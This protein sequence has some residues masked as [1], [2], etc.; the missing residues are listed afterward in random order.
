MLKTVLISILFTTLMNTSLADVNIKLSSKI[1][2]SQKK[3]IKSDLSVLEKFSFSKEGSDDFLKVFDLK[4][5]TSSALEEWLDQR[6]SWVI[7]QTDFKKL[8]LIDAG[9]VVYPNKNELPEIETPTVKPTGKGVV[10]MSNIGTAIYYIGKQSSKRMGVKISRGLFK[11]KE[12]VMLDSPRAGVIQ[13]GE[14]L[15][16][17]RMQVNRQKDN[18]VAN[19]L[20]RLQTFFH[21]ARHSDGHGKNLGFFH[22][23][24]PKGHDYAGLNACD[25]NINGPYTVGASLM[26]EFIRN[27][28]DCTT[29]EKETMKIIWLDSL[30]RVI[31][32]TEVIAENDNPEIKLLE[33]E[34]SLKGTL[35]ALT[36]S[37]EERQNVEKE[38]LELKKK[39]KD[40]AKLEG[41]IELVQSPFIDSAPEKIQ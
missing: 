29:T 21:E 37:A 20:G 6:V 15:F 32:E 8:K 39:L 3:A 27:C 4:S 36:S 41:L 35:L 28:D 12:E 1:K 13:I 14:G 31:K 23:V 25:R 22:A 9:F 26:K 40:L 24:C 2:K 7:P 34:I 38:L 30:N 33:L 19:S 11:S 16:M 18:S 10:V 5:L 17:R